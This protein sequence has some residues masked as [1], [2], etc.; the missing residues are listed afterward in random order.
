MKLET[1]LFVEEA[2]FDREGTFTELMTGN[3][4][5]MSR[6]TAPIYGAGA[7]RV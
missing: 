7:A 5:Y 2:I 1:E 4:G 6:S 3:H